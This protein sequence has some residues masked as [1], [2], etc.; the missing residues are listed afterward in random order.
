ML[1]CEKALG[2]LRHDDAAPDLGAWDMGA[3][4]MTAHF[5][6]NNFHF[7]LPEMLSYH[8]TW[9]DADYEPVLP[10]RQQSWVTYLVSAPVRALMAMA[11]RHRVM[12]ELSSMTD[13]ELSD[14]GMSRY[15]IPRVFDADFA[16]ERAARRGQYTG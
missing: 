6:K 3:K 5:K 9:D 4:P 14:L 2:A 12:N 7:H 16:A 1:Q 11:E 13:R 10:R 15:D 8:S